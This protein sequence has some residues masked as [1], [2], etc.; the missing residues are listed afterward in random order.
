MVAKH[1]PFAAFSASYRWHSASTRS[2]SAQRASKS[3]SRRSLRSRMTSAAETSSHFVAS[4]G[5]QNTSIREQC[6]DQPTYHRNRVV[7]VTGIREKLA[8]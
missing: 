5:Y 6:C 2:R 1:I 7:V 8:R 3:G 4:R